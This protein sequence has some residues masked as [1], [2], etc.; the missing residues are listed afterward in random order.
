MSKNIKK[1]WLIEFSANF[2]SRHLFLHKNL[3]RLQNFHGQIKKTK[4]QKK[5]LTKFLHYNVI[6]LCIDLIY[7]QNYFHQEAL[8]LK[9]S[10]QVTD[11]FRTDFFANNFPYNVCPIQAGHV[12]VQK[13]KIKT[14]TK[15]RKARSKST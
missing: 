6:I 9:C 4:Q 5:N 15:T 14:K 12:T 3:K 7:F 1:I 2:R 8:F 13:M 10:F 11:A